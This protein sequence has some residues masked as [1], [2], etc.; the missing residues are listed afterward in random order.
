MEYVMHSACQIGNCASGDG[1][2]ARQSFRGRMTVFSVTGF[3]AAQGSRTW[4]LADRPCGKGAARGSG[5]P[6]FRRID[7]FA[8]FRVLYRVRHDFGYASNSE[9]RAW[10][11]EFHDRVEQPGPVRNSGSPPRAWSELLTVKSGGGRTEQEG[12]SGGFETYSFVL[13]EDPAGNVIFS[14]RDSTFTFP[15]GS[16]PPVA[17][18]GVPTAPE[19]NDKIGKE[20]G[21]RLQ[22]VSLN[23]K[24]EICAREAK[25]KAQ[26]AGE[27]KT[28]DAS[29]KSALAKA[30]NSFT[31]SVGIDS[32]FVK[33]E[34]GDLSDNFFTRAE[35]ETEAVEG[36][37]YLKCMEGEDPDVKVDTPVNTGLHLFGVPGSDEQELEI[38]IVEFQGGGQS[39][40]SWTTEE[41]EVKDGETCTVTVSVQ[42]DAA[43]NCERTEVEVCD[44]GIAQS[45]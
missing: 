8:G 43:C 26:I 24:S 30:L 17:G 31:F 45:Q 16:E 13:L 37:A 12:G 14:E 21:T 29:Y 27:A 22:A 44:G 23:E 25:A 38:T 11:A 3:D 40:D 7:C 9:T 1:L 32:T 33:F 4:V 41:T 6:Q 28:R 34:F 2:T 15:E 42:C 5:T 18:P 35:A 20:A 36:R 10:A 39:C 19:D